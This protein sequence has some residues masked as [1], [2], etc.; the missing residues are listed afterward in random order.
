MANSPGLLAESH[1]GMDGAMYPGEHARTS[2]DKPAA[3]KAET[4]EVLTYRELDEQSNRLAQLLHAEGLSH[5][6]HI[7]LFME[8]QLSYFCVVWAA[9]R[10]GLYIT[11]INRYLTADE[12]EY[13][14]NDC[15]AKVLV[16][17]IERADVAAA[18]VGRVPNCTRL[19]MLGGTVPGWESYETAIAAMPTTKLAEE[20]LGDTMLYS[21]GTT[22]RPK[23]IKRVAPP[24]RVGEAFRMLDMFHEY[25]YRRDMVYL[26]PAPLYHAAPLGFTVG[27][28]R[29]GGTVVMM[30]RFDPL[31]ALRL[32][33]RHRV[34]HSQWV[35]TM[36]VRMLK[37]PEAECRGFDLS[38]HE[39]AIHAAAPCPVDVK[40]RMIEWWGPIIYEY[41]GAT[42][43]NGRTALDSA[44]WL[45]HP[46]SVGRSKLGVIHICD[47]EGAELP[48]GEDGL[49]YFERDAMP[50][51]YHNDA[52][53][54]EQAR[55]PA[56]LTWTTLGDIGHLDGEGYLYL[57]D[58]K[59]FMIISG[60]V[61]IY[62]QQIE[63]VLIGHPKVHDVAVIGVPNADLGEEVKAVVEAADGVEGDL[64][65]AEE[66]T[67]YLK[68]RVARYMV[69][70]SIDF[71]DAL[72]R[73]PTGKLYKA[74][75]RDQYRQA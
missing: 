28:Q 14:V 3:I 35:P 5:G 55:H 17:S 49:V 33:E 45:A 58:R 11:A 72:P 63:D 23:G 7:A 19:L 38:N 36:F 47:D 74:A 10:S 71:T 29:F 50:F 57:T 24:A 73:L 9:L 40:R 52:G 20:W 8:N 27:V 46:G 54:T 60:G 53:K 67:A 26:S 75:L 64:A 39:V 18:L 21:S 2:P 61:N 59:A 25:G 56:H 37:L 44:E 15:G 51:A 34:T 12:A 48:V 70:K 65:L 13:I 1:P 43:G 32:I 66:L 31:E 41:Y 68:Q 69:P 22:G 30:S 62:P 4:G 6:D 16:S 42:E